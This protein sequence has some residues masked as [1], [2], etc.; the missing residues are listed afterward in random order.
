VPS[1]INNGIWWDGDLSRELLDHNFDAVPRAGE[2]RIDKWNYEA[3]VAM[4]IFV[5]TGT[6]SNN[7]TKGN[8]A[9]QADLLGDWREEVIWRS[10]DSSELRLYATTAPTA[11][12][13]RTLMHDP[14]YRLSIAW[15]NVS[16]N[17]PPKPG[18]FLGTGMELPP[19]PDIYFPGR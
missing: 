14:V 11:V 10:Q 3:G 4:P 18:F 16:Y 6:F 1:S 19:K 8:P 2:G 5:A 12:K 15:Q 13:L 7:D 9:L 17:Q